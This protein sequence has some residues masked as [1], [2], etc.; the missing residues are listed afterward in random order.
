MAEQ[1][2]TTTDVLTAVNVMPP[3]FMVRLR[4]ILDA[5]VTVHFSHS[6]A[7]YRQPPITGQTHCQS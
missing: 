5:V 1:T 3:S 7:G 4:P 2:W 6:D